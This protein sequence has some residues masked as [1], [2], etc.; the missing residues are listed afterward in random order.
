MGDD[1][2]DIPLLKKAGFSATVQDAMDEV[3]EIAEYVAKRPAG[4]GAVRE[5]C[6]LLLKRL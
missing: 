3:L 5:V 4:N 2:M 6:E 1:E